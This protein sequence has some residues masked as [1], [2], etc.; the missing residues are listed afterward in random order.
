MIV[1]MRRIATERQHSIPATVNGKPSA[2]TRGRNKGAGIAHPQKIWPTKSISMFFANTLKAM[3]P[4]RAVNCEE[5]VRF[6]LTPGC[7]GQTAV[8][9]AVIEVLRQLQENF[10]ISAS[11]ITIQLCESPTHPKR[12]IA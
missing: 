6:R 2:K 8:L 12:S 3:K 1:R 11:E 4:M 10:G 9:T 7:K 5:R